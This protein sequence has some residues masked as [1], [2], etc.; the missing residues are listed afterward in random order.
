[1]MGRAD[2][3]GEWSRKLFERAF[4]W[5]LVWVVVAFAAGPLLSD[6]AWPFIWNVFT[7]LVLLLFAAHFVLFWSKRPRR[8]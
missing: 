8:K 2:S 5:F 4:Y 6:V 1:M 7:P 3:W